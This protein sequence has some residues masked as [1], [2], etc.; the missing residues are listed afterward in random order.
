MHFNSDLT[1][2]KKKIIKVY[3]INKLYKKLNFYFRLHNIAELVLL[4]TANKWFCCKYYFYTY[5]DWSYRH[6]SYTH[7]LF[8]HTI[9]LTITILCTHSKDSHANKLLKI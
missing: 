8:L 2:L 3:E 5:T 1:E 9:F 7:T 6:N 4:V